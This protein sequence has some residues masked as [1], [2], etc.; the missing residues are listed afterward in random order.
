MHL[1]LWRVESPFFVIPD[2]IRNPGFSTGIP[3]ELTHARY[4]TAMVASEA[5]YILLTGRRKVNRL[6]EI[7]FGEEQDERIHG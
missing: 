7:L 2:L 5:R 1:P 4:R 3:P 6:I